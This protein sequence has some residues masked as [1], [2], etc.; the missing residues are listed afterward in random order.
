MFKQELFL[1]F[2]IKESATM[3]KPNPMTNRLSYISLLLVQLA[4]EILKGKG[5]RKNIRSFAIC[6]TKRMS[7]INIGLPGISTAGKI[8]KPLQLLKRLS[9]N[10]MK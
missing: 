6:D 4:C 10:F 2:W 1:I 3:H 5:N 8:K 7:K 9:Y